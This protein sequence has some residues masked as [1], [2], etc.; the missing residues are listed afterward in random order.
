MSDRR[1]IVAF[2]AGDPPPADLIRR[3]ISKEHIDDGVLRIARAVLRMDCNIAY[4]GD[5]RG[6]GFAT[7]LS[8]DSGTVALGPRF[9]SFLGWPFHGNV[10]PGRIADTL[11]LCR[12]VRVETV[13]DV[14]KIVPFSE[15]PGFGWTMAKE[16]S[17]TRETLFSKEPCKDIDGEVVNPRIAQV[18]VAGKAEGFLGVM[19]GIAEEALRAV[20]S[21]L[22]VYVIGA[23]GGAAEL[24]ANFI[25]EG[26]CPLEFKIGS[27]RAD[28]NFKRMKSGAKAAG[29]EKIPAQAFRRLQQRVRA[30]HSDMNLLNNGLT[31][32]ENRTLMKTANLGKVVQLVSKGLNV[33]RG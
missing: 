12:Y 16:T 15:T 5:L 1:S 10:N 33:I 28:P 24:L 29:Q 4:A 8:D 3:G 9:I 27:H 22:A 19:P 26:K 32:A 21:G 20:E 11:G 17:N 31:E 30:V 18:L 7:E 13:S 25:C 6:G 23:F 14:S 2:S